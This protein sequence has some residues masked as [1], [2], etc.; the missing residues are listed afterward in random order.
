MLCLA[1]Q[2][3]IFHTKSPLIIADE[4]VSSLDLQMGENI[5]QNL[6]KS[7]KTTIVVT[8]NPSH[9]KYFDRILVMSEGTVI[10]DENMNASNYTDNDYYI[11]WLGRKVT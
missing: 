6:V 7:A 3:L 1:A 4:P 2:N 5:I 9:I 11:D 8:H 10:A